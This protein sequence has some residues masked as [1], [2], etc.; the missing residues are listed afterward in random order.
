MVM[1]L[2]QFIFDPVNLGGEF[3]QAIGNPGDMAILHPQGTQQFCQ[4]FLGLFQAFSSSFF[5]PAALAAS[6]E[7][8]P[9]Q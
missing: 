6:I 2:G 8:S 7:V 4:M 9:V 1:N 5:L 3:F